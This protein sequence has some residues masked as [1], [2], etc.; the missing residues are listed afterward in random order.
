[1]DSCSGMLAM[2]T[3]TLSCTLEKSSNSSSATSLQEAREEP[4]RKGSE[5]SWDRENR[6]PAV[7]GWER[8]E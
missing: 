1:M 4:E 8:S 5:S 7:Q 3:N 2:R 6:T